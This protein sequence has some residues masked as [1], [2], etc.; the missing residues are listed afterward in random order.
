MNTCEAVVVSDL[1][2][3]SVRFKFHFLNMDWTDS[4]GFKNLLL[5]NER[6]SFSFSLDDHD[7]S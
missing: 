6:F 7:L 1:N 5:A 4:I 2:L 3:Y